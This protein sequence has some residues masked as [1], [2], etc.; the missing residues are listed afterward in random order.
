MDILSEYTLLRDREA[1]PGGSPDIL[2][3]PEACVVAVFDLQSIAVVL[4][5]D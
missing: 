1:I 2:D 4:P 5:M 3:P